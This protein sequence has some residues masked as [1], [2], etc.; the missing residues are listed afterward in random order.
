MSKYRVVFYGLKDGDATEY[1]FQ[2]TPIDFI[3]EKKEIDCLFLIAKNLYQIK[4]YNNV[5]MKITDPSKQTI[6]K[7]ETMNWK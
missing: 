3:P 6:Y 2:E 4:G 5:V 7:T 1:P